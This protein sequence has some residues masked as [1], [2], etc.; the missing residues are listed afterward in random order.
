MTTNL[1]NLKIKIF[2]DGADIESMIEM[3]N[4]SYIKG[5]TTNPTLM[6]KAG[7]KNYRAFALDVLSV[8]KDKP[9][10]FEVFSDDFDE[11]IIQA[12]EI[13]SWGSNVNVKIPITNS[14]GQE[15]AS[16]IRNL[17]NSGVIVNV[18]AVMTVTQV[19]KIIDSIN[20]E[21]SAFISIFAGRIADTGIDPIFTMVESLKIIRSAPNTE[22]IW[23]SPRELL[24]II[25]AEEIGCHVITASSD[26]LKKLD[27][28]GKDLLQ[29][30]LETV[31][32]FKDDAM[33]S[34]YSIS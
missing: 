26:I 28:I 17:S 20:T 4:K 23:A 7:V 25:Q 21:A 14:K 32:M 11:M 22:L 18:T 5:L 12:K 16:V 34:G 2:A 9:I 29:Y 6:N 19:A 15:T 30:S 13:A 33:K 3:Y 31:K 1:E 10:S 8:V 27:L 24:N